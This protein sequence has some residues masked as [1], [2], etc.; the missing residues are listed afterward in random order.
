MKQILYLLIFSVLFY[1]VCFCGCSN[2]ENFAT[3]SKS[4]AKKYK[5]KYCD[6]T[7]KTQKEANNHMKNDCESR[8]YK[9]KEEKLKAFGGT[10][11]QPFNFKCTPKK[12]Y[13]DD[14]NYIVR[15]TGQSGSEM[16]AI[17]AYCTDGT[18][19]TKYGGNDGNEFDTTEISDG[20]NSIKGRAGSRVDQLNINEIEY[21]GNGGN[22][23]DVSCKSGKII[24]IYGRAGSRLDNFGVICD[25]N[26]E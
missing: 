16:D 10:G 9:S 19:S 13:S 7:F 24:G 23:F 20:L 2:Y 5:C 6:Q 18:S 25:N 21:G 1:Y 22:E 17:R 4:S 12:T 26:I 11:G 3:K 8:P 15:F 14:N